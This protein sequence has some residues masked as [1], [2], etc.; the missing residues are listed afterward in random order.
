MKIVATVV[1]G[2]GI[3]VLAFVALPEVK[4]PK[5]ARII[6]KRIESAKY[7][8]QNYSR[9]KQQYEDY[10]ARNYPNTRIEEREKVT[11]ASFI[12]LQAR[13]EIEH[14]LDAG[15]LKYPWR[16]LTDTRLI[17]LGAALEAV[18]IIIQIW[19]IG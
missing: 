16:W 9:L 1:S 10:K 12:D 11:E 4:R 2:I 14:M 17:V 18:S 15:T 3:V 8:K 6:F 19:F 13:V 7:K 5:W